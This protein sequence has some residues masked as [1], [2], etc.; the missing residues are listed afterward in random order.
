MHS[1]PSRALLRPAMSAQRRPRSRPG[2]APRPQKRTVRV[3]ATLVGIS[4][5]AISPAFYR[6]F[7][8]ETSAAHSRRSPRCRR[9]LRRST[10]RPVRPPRLLRVRRVLPSRRLRCLLTSRHCSPR[11]N[12]ATPP[13]QRRLS[14]SSR[15]MRHQRNRRST[16]ITI[17]MAAPPHRLPRRGLL[18]PTP[19]RWRPRREE[20]QTR[21]EQAEHLRSPRSHSDETETPGT[22]RVPGV[23]YSSTD[24]EW[25]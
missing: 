25:L 11:Y 17:I 8:P 22:G 15:Q 7:R 1:R 19:R 10:V 13:A 12:Q 2:K 4:S 6:L 23:L 14:T 3:R 20:P 9:T 5:P 16:A 24:T 18:P 21:P